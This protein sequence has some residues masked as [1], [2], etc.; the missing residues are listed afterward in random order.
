MTVS[1][2]S[3]GNGPTFSQAATGRSNVPGRAVGCSPRRTGAVAA[4]AEAVRRGPL[5]EGV[6]VEVSAAPGLPPVAAGPAD[7]NRLATFL[8]A[9]AALTGGGAVTA[10]TAA[11]PGGGASLTVGVAGPQ[12]DPAFLHRLTASTLTGQ[13][14]AA[15]LELAAAQSLVRRLGGELR[16]EPRPDGGVGVVV[17]LPGA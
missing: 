6:T 17:D 3:R 13:D 15:G 5:P 10:R 2:S 7:L 14:G 8:L 11:R 12:V 9:N 16:A 1:S 4:A